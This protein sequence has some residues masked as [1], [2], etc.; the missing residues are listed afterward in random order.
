MT[1]RVSGQFQVGLG[2]NRLCIPFTERAFPVR[3]ACRVH[4]QSV[5]G[6]SVLAP[7]VTYPPLLGIVE[8]ICVACSA[9]DS[10]KNGIRY[11]WVV[12]V[13]EDMSAADAPPQGCRGSPLTGL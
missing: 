9:G 13:N 6:P 1:H 8:G 12:P 10:E 3:M 4:L 7:G 11:F 5:L 2:V